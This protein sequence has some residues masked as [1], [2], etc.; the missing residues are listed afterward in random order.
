MDLPQITQLFRWR[1]PLAGEAHALL[2]AAYD[3]ATGQAVAVVSELADNPDDR[4]I[5]YDFS[6]VAEAALPLLRAKLS[7]HLGSVLWIAHFGDFSYHYVPGPET[8]T[9]ISLDVTGTGYAD[10]YEGDRELTADEVTRLLGGHP[11]TPVPE[12]LAG[13]G[14]LT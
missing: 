8:F 5:T 12:V 6:C 13:L 14:P 7:P 10:D 4:G 1:H 11:L 3:P 2:R 9:A